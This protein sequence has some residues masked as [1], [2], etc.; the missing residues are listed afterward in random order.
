MIKTAFAVYLEK[1]GTAGATAVD[2][3]NPGTTDVSAVEDLGHVTLPDDLR[4]LWER[5]DGMNVPDGTLMDQGLL[6]GQYCYLGVAEAGRDYQVTLSLYRQEPE[7]ETYWPKGFLPIGTPGDGSRLLI[8]CRA[9]SPTFGAVYD[10]MH[11]VGV[12]RLSNSLIRYF[13]TLVACVDQGVIKVSRTG[14]V[15]LDFS[16]FR[17]V[18]KRMN[19]GCDGFDD[20][21]APAADSED[22][23]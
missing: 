6:D 13:E 7:F 18:G 12:A 21:L 8:N 23:T 16:G 5:F 22:W 19:P 17:E 2:W 20:G 1:L 4:H 10:L 15:E 9:G 11:G 14:S 3:L